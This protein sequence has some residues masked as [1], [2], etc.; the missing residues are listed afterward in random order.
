MHGAVLSLRCDGAH[1]C[2]ATPTSVVVG[3]ALVMIGCVEPQ[4]RARLRRT[5]ETT[6]PLERLRSTDR[7][8]RARTQIPIARGPHIHAETPCDSDIQHRRVPRWCHDCGAQRRWNVKRPGTP[9]VWHGHGMGRPQRT[10]VHVCV[11]T[12]HPRRVETRAKGKRRGDPPNETRPSWA[13]FH[14]Y[15]ISCPG[16]PGFTIAI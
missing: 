4:G 1:L 11:C 16:V 5:Q 14:P 7:R 9:D 12:V 8:A 6:P 10:N 2:I 3:L 13:P 15:S